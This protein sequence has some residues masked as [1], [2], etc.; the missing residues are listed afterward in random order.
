MAKR[1]TKQK[2]TRKRVSNGT[3]T[4]ANVHSTDVKQIEQIEHTASTLKLIKKKLVN[5]VIDSSNGNAVEKETQ[6]IKSYFKKDSETVLE[7]EIM[8]RPNDPFCLKCLN[9][10][11]RGHKDTIIVM[12]ITLNMVAEEF[13]ISY[14]DWQT[15][16]KKIREYISERQ[17][18]RYAS[19]HKKDRMAAKKKQQEVID[20][21]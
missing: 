9:S 16:C 2:K 19:K 1:I 13:D 18:A 14:P 4:S 11:T 17:T 12:M 6:I 21:D 5:R 7:G 10:N 8:G 15:R 3:H 20:E